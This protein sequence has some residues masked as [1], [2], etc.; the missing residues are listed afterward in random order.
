MFFISVCASDMS[1]HVHDCISK[2][3][4]QILSYDLSCAVISKMMQSATTDCN[5]FMQNCKSGHSKTTV[6]RQE[7]VLD[8]TYLKSIRPVFALLQIY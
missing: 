2:G 4:Q 1:I 6:I 8:H 7:H 3:M 5:W